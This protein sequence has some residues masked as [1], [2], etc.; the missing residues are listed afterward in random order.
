M[1]NNTG[2]FSQVVEFW[3]VLAMK[4]L[5]RTFQAILLFSFVLYAIPGYSLPLKTQGRWLVDERTGERVKLHCVNWPAHILPML[6]E[7]LDKQPLRFIASELV[8]NNYNCVRFTFS[9]HMFTR[10]A[11][12]TIEESF[13]RLNLTKAKAGVIKNNPFVLKMTVPQAY[14]AVVDALGAFGL[15]VDADNH[16]SDPIW[17]CSNDD[18]N[19]FPNDPRFDPDE[20]IEG[21]GLVAQ[22]FKGKTQHWIAQRTP[23]EE[24]KC[25][26]LVRSVHHESSSTGSP[27]QS[28]CARGRFRLKFCHGLDILQGSFLDI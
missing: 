5:G 21:L 23:R 26:S 11:N 27:G 10:Y 24:S 6:A 17:C 4:M 13:D 12:L 28:R 25:N 22:L 19:G 7:G 1:T 8:K 15:M 3:R 14:E 18:E 16:M 20:W 9:I 2:S